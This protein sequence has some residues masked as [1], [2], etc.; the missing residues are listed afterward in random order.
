MMRWRCRRFQPWLVDHADGVLDAS[1]QQRLERHLARCRACRTDV[2]ALRDIPHVVRSST[3]PDPGDAFWLQQQR[4]IGRAI[5]NLPEPRAA[6]SLEW[7]REALQLSPWRYALTA[8]VALLVALSAY[9]MAERPPGS[10]NSSI[11]AQLAALDTEVL[12]ALGDLAE[13][14]TPG[15]DPLNYS[16]RE[17]E[18]AFAALAVGDLVGTHTLTH[19]PDDTELSDNELEGVDDLIGNVG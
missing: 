14:V 1:R 3:V 19:V 12:V 4:A 16:P 15:D 5:R 13:A 11:V 17:D 6:W 18:V 7:L 9:R 8:T 10:E 2:E